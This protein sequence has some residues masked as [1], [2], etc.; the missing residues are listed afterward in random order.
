MKF[1]FLFAAAVSVV[2]P[3]ALAESLDLATGLKI[4]FTNMELE[5]Y[6]AQTDVVYKTVNN[7]SIEAAIFVPRSILNNKHGKPAP[8]VVHFHG[9][10]LIVGTNPEPA[11]F[12]NWIT[13]LP[14]TYNAIIVSPAYRL[15]PEAKAY[16]ILEDIRDFWTWLH[17]PSFR[18]SL[19]SNV[20]PD[21]NKILAVGESAGGYLSIESALLF[22]PAAKIKAVI[23]QY[24]GGWIDVKGFNPTP[25]V[26][27][28]ALNAFVD[29]YLRT[30]SPGKDVRTQTPWPE[31]SDLFNAIFATGRLAEAY[32]TAEERTNTTLGYALKQ[33]KGPVPPIWVVQGDRDA[34]VPKPTTDEVIARIKQAHPRTEIKYTVHKGDHGFDS[35]YCLDKPFI[36]EGVEFV[37]KYWLKGGR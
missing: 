15:A 18:S 4:Q 34:L 14:K 33:A 37:Q 24:P 10:G 36:T 30:I 25:E 8:V 13:T 1:S 6:Y 23:A 28:P 21:L 2:A 26:V 17:G 27:D 32:G 9:G 5:E 7:A 20:S 12:G 29:D 35:F 16:Q 11:F 31:K 3:A 19:P 22:N